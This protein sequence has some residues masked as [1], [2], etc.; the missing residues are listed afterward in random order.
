MA[1]LLHHIKADEVSP[2]D[3]PATRRR[4]LLHKNDAA[5]VQDV[6]DVPHESEGALLDLLRKNGVS[7]D[8]QEAALMIARLSKGFEDELP[9][10][11]AELLKVETAVEAAE[12]VAKDGEDDV[13]VEKRT[14]SIE[15][16][17]DL[18]NAITAIGRAKDQSRAMAHIKKRAQAL[19]LTRLL[20]DSWSGGDAS[21]NKGEG[22]DMPEEG[23]VSVA[24][25]VKKEDGSWDLSGVSPEARPFYESVLKSHDD[26]VEKAEALEKRVEK[27]EADAV[28]AKDKLAN[29]EFVQKA[30]TEYK[31]LGSAED[32]A[33]ILKEASEK[34]EAETFEKLEGVLKAANG[35]IEK[36]GLFKEFGSR[37]ETDESAGDAMSQIEKMAAELVEKSTETLTAEQAFTKAVATP[38]GAALYA[39]YMAET[40][41]RGDKVAGAVS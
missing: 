10:N 36:G 41:G 31:H 24:V 39:Q 27:A 8:G 2:V 26:A 35:R 18:K 40:A 20:P 37:G 12:D 34:L 1:Q 7:E 4:F 3:R 23:N 5:A 38:K 28:S 32:L 9:E 17:G 13:D 11:L 30:E 29:N 15:N 21:V 25:P 33:P 22:P 6:L 16:Q 14:F 19:G